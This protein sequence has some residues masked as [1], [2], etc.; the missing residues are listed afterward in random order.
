MVC[1]TI[2]AIH[3]RSYNLLT[4]LLG[5]RHLQRSNQVNKIFS[6]IIT[7]GESKSDVAVN[8]SEVCRTQIVCAKKAS[9]ITT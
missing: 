3:K 9:L 7:N 5:R 2:L 8:L 6:K 1:A 4:S